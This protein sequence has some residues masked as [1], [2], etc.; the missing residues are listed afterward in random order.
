MK[1]FQLDLVDMNLQALKYNGKSYRYI[2]SL[3]DIFSRLHWLV[4]LQ[5]ICASQGTFCLNRKFIE[6]WATRQNTNR[7]WQSTKKSIIKVNKYKL[8]IT[9]IFGKCSLWVIFFKELFSQNFLHLKAHRCFNDFQH[10]KRKKF[11]YFY[12]LLQ[13]LL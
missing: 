11:P 1:Q 12:N 4:P 2:L 6:A 10:L 9:L 7:Q 13:M 5:R 8:D 3:T